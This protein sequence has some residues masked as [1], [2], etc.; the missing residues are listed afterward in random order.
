MHRTRRD[1]EQ[2]YRD[3]M[4]KFDPQARDR[5]QG[6]IIDY[7]VEKADPFFLVFLAMGHLLSLVEAAPENWKALFDEFKGDLDAWTTQN[8]RTLEA[9]NQQSLVSERLIKSFQELSSLTAK[10]SEGTLRL[11]AD[12][13]RLTSELEAFKRSWE[14][15][16]QSHRK[17]QPIAGKTVQGYGEKNR[18][19]R[20]NAD[21]GLDL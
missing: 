14:G 15:L 4:A 5:I 20:R 13:T 11:K 2:I 19:V 6:V 17:Q 21:L 8:L 10:S 1:P 18:S 3:V 12:L 9:I 16:G 7:G